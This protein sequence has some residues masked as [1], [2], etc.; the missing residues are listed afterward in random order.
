M[1]YLALACDFDGTLAHHQQVAEQT[2]AALERLRTSG[3][4]LILLT[5]RRLEELLSIFSHVHLFD[6]VVAE[7]GALL[8][9]PATREEKPLGSPPPEKFLQALRDRGV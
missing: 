7:N 2:V 3:R 9:R 6:R 8:Y 1:R 5:G 4:R